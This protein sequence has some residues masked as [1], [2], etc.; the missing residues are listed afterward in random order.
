MAVAVA[1]RGGFSGSGGS[2]GS[3]K[4]ESPK[5]KHGE[6]GKSRSQTSTAD[7]TIPKDLG[8]S[9]GWDDEDL[10]PRR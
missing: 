2:G 7:G 3:G 1:S 5:K 9:G 6:P 10:I 8:N 4:A